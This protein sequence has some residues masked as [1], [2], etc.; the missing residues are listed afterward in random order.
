[1]NEFIPNLDVEPY[2]KAMKYVRDETE[3]H[4]KK[5]NYKENELPKDIVNQFICLMIFIY[6]KKNMLKIIQN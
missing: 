2:L 6:I 4:V 1:M 3:Y 5:N